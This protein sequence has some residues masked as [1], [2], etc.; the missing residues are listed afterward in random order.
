MRV[1][2]RTG[3]SAPVRPRPSLNRPLRTA[4]IPRPAARA[5][6]A[7]TTTKTAV[8]L[9]RGGMGGVSRQQGDDEAHLG[10]WAAAGNDT[11]PRPRDMRIDGVTTLLPWLFSMLLAGLVRLTAARVGVPQLRGLLALPGL[12]QVYA[13]AWSAATRSGGTGRRIEPLGQWHPLAATSR[14]AASPRNDPTPPPGPGR[15]RW[16]RRLAPARDC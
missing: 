1:L 14:A 12:P 7:V 2:K 6:A 4:H 15:A 8:R 9:R 16:C 3:V 5:M 11:P 10:P 13:S